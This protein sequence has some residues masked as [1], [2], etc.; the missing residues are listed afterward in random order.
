MVPVLTSAGYTHNTIIP[1]EMKLTGSVTHRQGRAIRLSRPI[2][3]HPQITDL[4]E[5]IGQRAIAEN[6]LAAAETALV[7]VG[8]GSELD[9]AS[10]CT[11]Q[12]HA[13]QLRCRFTFGETTAVFLNQ[14][15]EVGR[16]FQLTTLP[17]LVVVPNLLGGSVHLRRDI[18][19]L[20]SVPVAGDKYPPEPAEAHGRRIIL[21]PPPFE[22]PSIVELILA[23]AGETRS[24]N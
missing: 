11:T 12:R 1:R 6:A 16:V 10:A 21:T 22:D 15:P 2:G 13:E 7:I 5:R 4:I 9:P 24:S 17:H 20:L 3:E 8:H 23:L 14:P 19:R 18:P